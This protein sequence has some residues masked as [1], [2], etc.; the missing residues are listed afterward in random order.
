MKFFG[1]AAMP[2]K[3]FSLALVLITACV[4][5][6]GCGPEAERA[7]GGGPGA[8]IGNRGTVVDIHGGHL[9]LPIPPRRQGGHR[10]ASRTKIMITIQQKREGDR[11]AFDSLA[12]LTRW[13]HRW[14]A[15]RRK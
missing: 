2:S 7:R 11:Q 5:L 3:I 9:H 10:L 1:D 14:C 8:D 4:L 13:S 12:A 15:Y 6:S